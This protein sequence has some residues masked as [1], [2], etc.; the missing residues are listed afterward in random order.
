VKN[1]ADKIKR[2]NNKK[3]NLNN[4]DMNVN[5]NICRH[6]KTKQTRLNT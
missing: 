1:N 6:K 4:K 5:I 3:L 2:P